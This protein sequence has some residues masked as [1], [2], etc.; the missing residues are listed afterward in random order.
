MDP[1][2]TLAASVNA[3]TRQS[4]VPGQAGSCYCYCDSTACSCCGS[5]HADSAD[6]CSRRRRAGRPALRPVPGS[7]TSAVIP[8]RPVSAPTGRRSRRDEHG[9]PCLPRTGAPCHAIPA[10]AGSSRR[11][12]LSAAGRDSRCRFSASAARARPDNP[13]YQ[14]RTPRHAARSRSTQKT[15]AERFKPKVAGL[16]DSHAE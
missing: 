14:P 15:T 8:P 9:Q 11:D 1:P 10:P 16:R 6:Y 3:A 7:L 4:G 2:V 13:E 12:A 5:R